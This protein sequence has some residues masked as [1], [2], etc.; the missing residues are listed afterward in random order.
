MADTITITRKIA[1]IPVASDNK[2]WKKRINAFLEKDFP[3]RIETKKRQIKNTSKPEKKEDYK[4][5]L[6]EL[7]K[8][9]EDFK[10]NGITEYT[11]KMVSNYTYSFVRDAMKNEAI[12]KNYIWS[13]MFSKM[14]ED[15]VGFLKTNIEKCKWVQENI[16]PAFRVTGK[17]NGN[18][19]DTAGITNPLGAYGQ[20]FKQ[21][22]TRELKDFVTKGGLDGEITIPTHKPNSPFTIE[23]VHFNI[24]HEYESLIELK[25]NIGKPN[26]DVYMNYGSKGSPTLMRFRMNFGHKKNKE[27]L[28][29]TIIKVFTG[30]YQCC[31]S[32]IQID[33]N[34]KIILNLTLKIPKIKADLD[35][36]TVVGV[37]LGLAVPAVCALNNDLYNKE[38]IGNGKDLVIKRTKFQNER[39]QLQ[40]A[41]K[42]S[43]GGHGRKR[44]LVALERL[45]D[46][47]R[48]FVETY[49]HRVSKKVVD[50]AV[51]HR[52]KYINIENLRGYD[53]SEFVLRNWSF[54]KLQQYITYKAEKYGIEVRKINPSFTSQVCSFCGHWEEGQ[55]KDQATF[56]CKNPNC[57]S[58]KLHTVNADYNAARNIAM[59]T[60]FTS[61]K[62]ECSKKTIQD[63]ADYYGI[64]LEDD[65]NNDNKKAA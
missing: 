34:N 16:K 22:I 10:E 4:K 51:K 18:I 8:Q 59:S 9:Y 23:K 61:E 12:R 31:G 57:K 28:I 37:D 17:D 33:K 41:L 2:D 58:H 63:A 39:K 43:K 30:E 64:I 65:K 25:K 62:F 26:C 35:K 6:I 3:K 14:V 29:S 56:K 32:S 24:T 21:D 40:K 27:E 13:Y 48:N 5:Q 19:Y 38:Y 53:S 54:Y 50:Y 11:H 46:K 49:C 52:A 1:L 47:E 45:E 42:L 7:E 44:K 36:D 20:A 15:G 60:M 55:R